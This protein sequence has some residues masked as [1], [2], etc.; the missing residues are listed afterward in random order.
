MRKRDELLGEYVGTNCPH[1]EMYT[2]SGKLRKTL[3][4]NT[5]Q[6][7]RI[8]QSIPS[9]KAEPFKMWLAQVGSERLNEIADPEKAFTRGVEYYRAF[10]RSRKKCNKIKTPSSTATEPSK[11]AY[12]APTE[13]E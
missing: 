4:A 11:T 1:V 10:F 9:P 7:L 12:I 6:I 3:A 5:T 8:T 2:E 13:T